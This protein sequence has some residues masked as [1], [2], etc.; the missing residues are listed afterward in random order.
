MVSEYMPASG[1]IF[2]LALQCV[3][4]QEHYHNVQEQSGYQAVL[5]L[6]SVFS[7]ESLMGEQI[8]NILVAGPPS[9]NNLSPKNELC[10][11]TQIEASDQV[12]NLFERQDGDIDGARSKKAVWH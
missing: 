6:N 4:G 11:K 3:V 7:S 9:S 10:Q 1:I 5:R 2:S 8:V 12:N